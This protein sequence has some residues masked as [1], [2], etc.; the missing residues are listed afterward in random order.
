MSL[1]ALNFVSL[2][3]LIFI[4]EKEEEEK[5]HLYCKC[6]ILQRKYKILYAQ[7]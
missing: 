1:A 2:A 3:N 5:E 4:T 6:V 7:G